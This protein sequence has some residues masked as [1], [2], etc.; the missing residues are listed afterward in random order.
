[1][2]NIQ[3]WLKV[4]LIVIITLLGPQPAAQAEQL[5]NSVKDCFQNPNKCQDQNFSPTKQPVQK[6]SATT[7]ATVGITIWDF[8]RMIFATIFVVALLY[9]LLKFINKRSKSFKSTQLVENL[10]GTSLGANRSVQIVKIGSGL[11]IVGVGENVQMLKEIDNVQERKEILAEYNNKMEQLVQPSDIV[12]KLFERTKN[13]QPQKAKSL[14]FS[15]LL[16]TQLEEM[17]NGRKKLFEE[18]EK[19]GSDEQ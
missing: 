10:G 5:N 17:A 1:M 4:A 6:G 11:F 15:S 13:W 16:K 19:K 8:V 14:P 3:K 7:A 9:F 18:M 12:T 2:L